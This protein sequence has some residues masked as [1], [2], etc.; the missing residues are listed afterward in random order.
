MPG[1][2][3]L[4]AKKRQIEANLTGLFD[5]VGN[6]IDAAIKCLVK[7]DQGVCEALIRNDVKLN[8]KRRMLEQDC[9]VAIASQQ[10]VAHDLRDIVADMRIASELERMGDYAADI[11]ASVLEMDGDDLHGLGLLDV[12]RMSGLCQD[13]LNHA[14]RAHREGDTTL[15]R[16]V[17]ASDDELDDLQQRLVGTLMDAMRADPGHVHN[18]SR[19]LWIAHN[20]E[21][22][23]DRAANIAAQVVFRIEGIEVDLN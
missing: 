3:I 2:H 20:L 9:L 18:G 22:C 17:G 4:E 19:M 6:A 16:R 15:A 23:G 13:M 5:E 1:G 11:A 14:M 10:P 8:E 12:Q 21:R 7:K